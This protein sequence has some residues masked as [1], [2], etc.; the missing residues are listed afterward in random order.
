MSILVPFLRRIWQ[1]FGDRNCL[2]QRQHANIAHR[3]T[4]LR[5]MPSCSAHAHVHRPRPGVGGLESGAGE[6]K[7]VPQPGTLDFFSWSWT[8]RVTCQLV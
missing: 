4:R 6:V 7:K 5:N 1:L 8:P 3:T 2:V